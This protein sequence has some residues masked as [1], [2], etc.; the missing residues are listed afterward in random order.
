MTIFEKIFEKRILYLNLY[1]RIYVTI[2]PALYAFVHGWIVTFFNMIE[3][4]FLL[5]FYYL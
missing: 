4:L 5:S 2:Q 1:D 3:F